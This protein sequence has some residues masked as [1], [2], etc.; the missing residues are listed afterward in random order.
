MFVR[1]GPHHIRGEHH[2]D[3][4]G[5][6]FGAD[7]LRGYSSGPEEEVLSHAG[8]ILPGHPSHSALAGRHC[9]DLHVR[10]RSLHT[11]ERTAEAYRGCAQGDNDVLVARNG[12]FSDF[13]ELLIKTFWSNLL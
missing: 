4:H 9:F 13:D 10:P 5:R 12:V 2:R 11:Q 8:G 1:C 6:G 7:L 3:H